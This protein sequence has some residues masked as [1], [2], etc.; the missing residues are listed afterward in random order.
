[1]AAGRADRLQAWQCLD[2]RGLSR[3]QSSH[4]PMLREDSSWEALVLSVEPSSNPS[5]SCLAAALC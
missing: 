3:W 2:L 5:G 1:M 4:M